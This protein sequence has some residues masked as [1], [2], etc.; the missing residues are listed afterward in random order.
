MLAHNKEFNN[1][2][3]HTQYSICEGAVRTSDLA[4]YC[5]ENP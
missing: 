2:K 4:K 5:K 3:V 1:I